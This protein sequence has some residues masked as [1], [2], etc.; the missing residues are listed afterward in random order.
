MI[1]YSDNRLGFASNNNIGA[2]GVPPPAVEH[3]G[4]IAVEKQSATAISRSD[5][6][7]THPPY[8]YIIIIILY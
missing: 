4:Y 6:I 7:R 8:P 2:G 3:R 5:A 1:G